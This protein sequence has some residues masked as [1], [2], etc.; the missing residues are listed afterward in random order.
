MRPALLLSILSC[1]L[2]LAW[3]PVLAQEGDDD[4][5][6]EAEELPPWERPPPQGDEGE[7][8]GD[9]GEV[10]VDHEEE[11]EDE[12][13]GDHEDEDD[14]YD[15]EDEDEDDDRYDDEDE[16]D[17]YD[18]ED[19]DDED[20]GR[21]YRDPDRGRS[22]MDRPND[23]VGY[24]R[25]E[26]AQIWRY[27]SAEE[28]PNAFA[29]LLRPRVSWGV[30]TAQ[31]QLVTPYKLS[32]AL[33]D[34]DITKKVL[35]HQI[36]GAAGGGAT[37]AAGLAVLLGGTVGYGLSLERDEDERRGRG[38]SGNPLDGLAAGLVLGP[39]LIGAGTGLT[40]GILRRTRQV[41]WY[42]ERDDAD[43]AIEDY[44][45]KLMK[46]LDLD[47][48]DIERR[49]ALPVQVELHAVLAPGAAGLSLTW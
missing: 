14:R 39:I 32:R 9:E 43:F 17:R 26:E 49:G 19:E 8:E 16:D 13:E 31:G 46:M 3:S 35:G 12:D 24:Y 33:G 30:R 23:P 36:A 18:D 6:A 10:E 1:L 2:L 27:R 44:N 28:Y 40:I 7:V 41:A 37:I 5:S 45:S 4:D 11:D 21:S 48:E 47:R 20:Y 42:Y 25:A 29:A 22:A 34:V 15:D 38:G